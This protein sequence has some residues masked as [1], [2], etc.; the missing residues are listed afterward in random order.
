MADARLA[1]LYRNLALDATWS[2]SSQVST[3]PARHL[4][5]PVRGEPWRSTGC[6]G[7]W[8][9][10]QLPQAATVGAVAVVASNLQPNATVLIQGS[11]TDEWSTPFE[12][13]LVPWEA[14]HT[15]TV[16]KLLDAP[17]SFPWWRFYFEDPTN[18]TGYI[19]I[20]VLAFGPVLDFGEAPEPIAYRRIDPSVVGVTDSQTPH[21]YR[22]DAITEVTL[23]LGLLTQAMAVDGLAEA[24]EDLGQST[25]GV[26]SVF[27][28]SPAQDELAKR[29]NVYGSLVNP[30]EL[31]YEHV[32]H[33][34]GS[35]VF[36]ESL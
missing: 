13:P 32:H 30:L 27:A 1:L 36:R 15:R 28:T 5:T 6:A 25:D 8:V 18:P 33:W 24:F 7:E 11:A 4:A 29:L 14:R 16:W 17:Q 34:R 21:R 9:K 2:A 12:A 3:L 23:P 26:L 20:G 10:A 31:G 35:L 19:Q 22:K